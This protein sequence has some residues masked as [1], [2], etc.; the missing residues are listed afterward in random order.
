MGSLWNTSKHSST[1]RKVTNI[2]QA[3]YGDVGCVVPQTEV[4]ATGWGDLTPSWHHLRASWGGRAEMN[5][6]LTPHTSILLHWERRFSRD[7]AF[8]SRVHFKQHLSPVTPL[9]FQ[10][11]ASSKHSHM[12]IG[13]ICS[14]DLSSFFPASSTTSERVHQ[15]LEHL[16]KLSHWENKAGLHTAM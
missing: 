12:T 5:A 2:L 1:P 4:G 11:P 3:S 9:C 13:S 8:F 14:M 16:Y 7:E 15:I 6:T 10:G